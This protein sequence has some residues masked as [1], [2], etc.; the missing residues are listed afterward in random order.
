MSKEGR[1]YD[2]EDRLIEFG[3]RIIR[4]AEALPKTR[5]GNHIGGQ[6]IRSG[7]SPAPNYGEAQSAESRSDF[8]HKLK[9]C[10]K[11][12]RETRVWLL[13]IAKANLI[14]SVSE[15]DPLIDESNQLI[16]IFVSSIKTVRQKCRETS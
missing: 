8:V 13:M 11:E 1:T 16:S 4:L 9:I 6:I 14:K 5:A 15:I 3:V 12:L 2:L 7:S 10:L